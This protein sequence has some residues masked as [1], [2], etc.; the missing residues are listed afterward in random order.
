MPGQFGVA[1]TSTEG[2]EQRQRR[3][4]GGG[5]QAA[6]QTHTLVVAGEPLDGALGLG[7]VPPAGLRSQRPKR[8]A[9]HAGQPRQG[10]RPHRLQRHL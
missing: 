7:R 6:R 10:G 5:A 3:R 9:P 4:V 1:S 2:A 8:R